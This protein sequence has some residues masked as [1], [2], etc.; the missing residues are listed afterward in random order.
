MECPETE[1]TL[2]VYPFIP[3]NRPLVEEYTGLW[4]GWC[5]LGYVA[6]ETMKE[7]RGDLFVAAAYHNGDDMAFDGKTP[8]SPGGYPS[9]YVNRS[10]SVNLG[11]IYTEWDAWRRWI[12]EGGVECGVEWA[13][14]AHAS[15]RA[16]ST[17][18]FIEGR[19]GR[20]L[21]R[22]IHTCGRRAEQPALEAE[23]L[24]FRARGQGG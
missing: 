13:D 18:R 17:A 5:P 23:Q 1:G 20:G 8:N 7:R 10:A 19:S 12:P 11:K 4:C 15:L 3:A 21:P 22:V 2:K 9:A 14:D 16:T 6:L 24:L